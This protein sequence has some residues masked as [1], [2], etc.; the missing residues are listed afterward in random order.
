MMGLEHRPG[1]LSG[2]VGGVLVGLALWLSDTADA[3][4]AVLLGWCAAVFLHLAVLL[5]R[6][7]RSGR[8]EFRERAQ[9]VDEDKWAILIGTVGA[10]LASLVAVGWVLAATSRPAPPGTVALCIGVIVLSWLFIHG[11]F[12]VHYAHEAALAPGTV[13]FP[14]NPDPDFL[15]FLYLA[16]IIGMTCQVSDATTNG[17]EIRRLV[18]LHGLVSFVF[19]V[20]I[21][22]ATVNVSASLVVS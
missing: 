12:A 6:S 15:E 3:P 11:L 21:L 14:G 4:H 1:L 7:F 13:V 17:K 10:A 19:N 8:K 20:V 5:N 22:A 16:L 18:L 2:S 9:L